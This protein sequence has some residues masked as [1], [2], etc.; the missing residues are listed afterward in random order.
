MIIRVIQN[1]LLGR[2]L[3]TGFFGAVLAVTSGAFAQADCFGYDEPIIFGE[4]D[5]DSPQLHDSIARYIL[6]EGYGCET[7]I[8]PGSTIPLQQGTVRGDV[9]V[10]MEV[11]QD[12]LP[13]FWVEAVENG[14]VVDL[15]PNFSD[16]EQGWYVPHYV[17]EGDSER[18]IEPMAPNLESVSDLA[19]YKELFRDPEQPEM[20]RFYNGVIGWQAETVNTAKLKAYGLTEEFT[21][22]RPGTTVGLTS[23]LEGAYLRG[24]PWVGYQWE[25]TWVLGK[26]DMIRLEEPEYTDEC[27]EHLTENL[28]DPERACAFPTSVV[29]IAVSAR[30]AEEAPQEVLQFLRDYETTSALTAAQLAY[31]QEEGATPEEAAINFL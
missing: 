6:E 24:Q 31:M 12:Q 1:S 7:R 9:D 30:F 21:N 3:L 17:I 5:W 28:E 10:L 27:W 29:T 11:W 19:E 4:Q 2:V 25:P 8:I 15:G 20:G 16:A 13:D 22:F 14:D 26:L 18:G 23:S